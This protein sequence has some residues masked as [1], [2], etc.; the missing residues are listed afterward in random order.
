[1]V[2]V[3]EVLW[4][5]SLRT[6]YAWLPLILAVSP[7]M[8]LVGPG[9]SV[10]FRALDAAVLAAAAVV[11]YRLFRARVEVGE[12]GVVVRRLGRPVRLAW[13]EVE[14]FEADGSKWEA[15]RR[16]R[17]RLRDGTAVA[18]GNYALASERAVALLGDLDAE[19]ARRAAPRESA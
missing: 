2:S 19:L 8:R 17:V 10:P 16:L 6:A 7:A 11:A 14:R 5:R 9:T 3:G 15:T 4:S 1:M 12:R 13:A 18:L